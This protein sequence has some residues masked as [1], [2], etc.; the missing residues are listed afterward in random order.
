MRKRTVGFFL[1]FLLITLLA[2]SQVHGQSDAQEVIVKPV[3]NKLLFEMEEITAKAGSSL[4]VVM[5]NT[6]T[7]PVMYHNVVFLNV[8]PEDSDTIN[9]VGVAAM[10]AGT[11][12]EYIPDHE[13]ILAYTPLA[14]PGK[15]TEVVITVPPPGDYSYICSYLGH[16]VSMKG[17]LHSVP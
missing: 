11:E 17:V 1:S 14:A 9:E 5:D 15:R 12:K 10:K 3:G 2:G 6:A 8:G 16:Y 7:V 4:K 13:A